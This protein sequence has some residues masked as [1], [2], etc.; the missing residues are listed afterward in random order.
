MRFKTSSSGFSK[1]NSGDTN[2]QDP[3]ATALRLNE[4]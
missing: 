1:P 2:K 4:D 3:T